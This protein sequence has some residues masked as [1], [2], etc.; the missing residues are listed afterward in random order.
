[1]RPSEQHRQLSQLPAKD[2]EDAFMAMPR[3]VQLR[4][5]DWYKENKV[6]SQASSPSYSKPPQQH[7]G[8]PSSRYLPQTGPPPSRSQSP[9]PRS[10]PPSRS[11]SPQLRYSSGATIPGGYTTAELDNLLRSLGPGYEQAYS[12]E[13]VG[14]VL[15]SLGNSNP[16]PL[17]ITEPRKL[18]YLR[19]T[20]H[21]MISG[22]YARNHFGRFGRGRFPNLG[23]DPRSGLPLSQRLF[24]YGGYPGRGISGHGPFDFGGY[25]GGG[26]FGPF[27]L[28]QGG[29]PDFEGRRRRRRS[30]KQQEIIGV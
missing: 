10:Y 7:S 26:P 1:M 4:L 29:F 20:L 19:E 12:A 3:S 24:D 21:M 16:T 17:P 15:L 30:S 14:R 13:D 22:L 5:D 11:P 18:Q 28:G 6:D 9:Q 8:Q 27:P 2:A 25:S 23:G